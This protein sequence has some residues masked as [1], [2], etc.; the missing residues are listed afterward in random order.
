MRKYLDLPRPS[1]K[2]AFCLLRRR[3]LPRGFR[4]LELGRGRLKPVPGIPGHARDPQQLLRRYRLRKRGGE[5]K[6]AD[7][8]Q[9]AGVPESQ[10]PGNLCLPFRSLPC[11]RHLPG[12][13]RVSGANCFYFPARLRFMPQAFFRLSGP[14][15]APERSSTGYRVLE[16]RSPSEKVFFPRGLAGVGAGGGSRGPSVFCRPWSGFR[17]EGV[18]YPGSLICFTPEGGAST[19]TAAGLLKDS[20]PPPRF[21]SRL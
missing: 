1:I 14:S 3:A 13:P 8:P 17:G 20:V 15:V 10:A 6:A 16:L 2:L 4:G 7:I 19:V 12:Y 11:L 9:K 5:N 21:S 18:F